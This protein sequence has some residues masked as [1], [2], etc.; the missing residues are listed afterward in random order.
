MGL[1]AEMTDS[2]QSTQH[3]MDHGQIDESFTGFG[4]FFIIFTQPPIIVQPT[5]GAFDN[6]TSGQYVKSLQITV[7]FD[8]FPQPTTCL[9]YPLGISK[10]PRTGR[11]PADFPIVG[12][13]LF[14]GADGYGS[15]SN[16]LAS[17]T[18]GVD[19]WAGKRVFRAIS[20]TIITL[21]TFSF[22]GKAAH[23]VM[24]STRK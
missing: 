21:M 10:N 13:Q 4:Q 12:E 2:S 17:K 18:A 5:E 7:A 3:D 6:P 14:S 15:Y 16:W 9:S 24:A 22:T 8:N 23:T 1:L 19:S 20:V 11:R